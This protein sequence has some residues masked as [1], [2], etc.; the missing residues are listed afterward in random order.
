MNRILTA[1]LAIL[2]GGLLATVIT[3]NSYLSTFSNPVIASWV[4]H[5]VGA[6]VAGALVLFMRGK[7]QRSTEKPPKWAY[8][9]G[10][11]G[12]LTVSIAAITVNSELGLTGTLVLTIVG[13]TLFGMLADQFGWFGLAKRPLNRIDYLTVFLT[14]TGSLLVITA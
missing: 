2:G 12:A 11:A 10:V 13:Q 14:V 7:N 1:L 3:L 4:C 8:F 6:V 5:G 9:G